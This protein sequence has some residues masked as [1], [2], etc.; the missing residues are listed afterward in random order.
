[1]ARLHRGTLNA[2]NTWGFHQQPLLAASIEELS[3]CHLWGGAS[4]PRPLYHDRPS[5]ALNHIFE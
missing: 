2:W 5:G 3:N 4:A 1:M